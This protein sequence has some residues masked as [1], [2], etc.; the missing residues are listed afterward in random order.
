MSDR[1]FRGKEPYLTH[2]LKKE[3]GGMGRKDLRQN[4]GEEDIIIYTDFSKGLF[5]HPHYILHQIIFYS[6]LEITHP[7]MLKSEAF[8]SSHKTYQLIPQVIRYKMLDATSVNFESSYC[9]LLWKM[10]S[11]WN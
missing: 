9:I 10:L 1:L 5:Y 11:F 6:E 7:E 3:L 8:G 4:L 2:C